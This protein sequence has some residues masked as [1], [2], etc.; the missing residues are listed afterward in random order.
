MTILFYY[1]DGISEID[2]PYF[3]TLRAQQVYFS[4]H[5]VA[6][7]EYA[8]FPPY[9]TNNIRVSSDELNFALN[10]NYLSFE[11]LGKTYYYFIESFD[12]IND[13]LI[14]LHIV[15]DNIQT[16]F[17]N[18]KVNS[19]VIERKFIDRF[20]NNSFNR[21]YIRENFG[22]SNYIEGSKVILED[23]SNSF[24]MIKLSSPLG[25]TRYPAQVID[26]LHSDDIYTTSFWVISQPLK[27]C[28]LS[29]YITH[30]GQ[31][32][33]KDVSFTKNYQYYVTNERTISMYICPFIP[34]REATYNAISNTYVIPTCYN[35]DDGEGSGNYVKEM[36]SDLKEVYFIANNMVT[37]GQA[38]KR[39][40]YLDDKYKRYD[41]GYS[42][43]VNI[44]VLFDSKYVPALIDNNYIKLEFGSDVC[45]TSYP[46]YKLEN[47]LIYMHYN[48]NLVDGTR[49]Y[50]LN[51][52]TNLDDN[53]SCGVIDDNILSIELITDRW[54]QYQ[55][56][57]QM[58]WIGA[59]S[60]TAI[61]A[62]SM[63]V[64]GGISSKIAANNLDINTR[65]FRNKKTIKHIK[66]NSKRSIIAKNNYDN[67]MLE[68]EGNMINSAL[69]NDDILGQ[70]IKDINVS[71]MPPSQKTNG[72]MFANVTKDSDIWYRISKVSNFEYCAWLYHTIGYLV[73]E[74]IKNI[75]D[76]IFDR[77]NTRYYYN[78][79]KTKDTIVH[80]NVL[81][82]NEDTEDINRRLEKGLR[83]WNVENNVTIG[84]FQYDNVEKSYL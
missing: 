38:D 6:R 74:P 84:T 19:G 9:Y 65:D 40:T 63:L 68:N 35:S 3:S 33:T 79:L 23:G 47:S 16:F 42:K 52:G 59:I 78:V 48:F 14:E 1:I 56:A 57:N 2:T 82:S 51:I 18:I 39:V 17:F 22:D 24:V 61:N 53:Y 44:N 34:Y 73:N 12:Y 66:P 81:E 41:F 43:N 32:V 21:N 15:K 25:D 8:F 55:S 36:E 58:R 26:T 4:N 7:I 28:K 29:G 45:N 62:A 83:L 80:L 30:G 11:F 77:V 37:T 54:K 10:V 67:A 60:N 5:F 49:Y 75:E 46:L 31:S 76:H 64:T 13:N 69:G 50:L 71:M 70:A 20:E 72:N 27:D